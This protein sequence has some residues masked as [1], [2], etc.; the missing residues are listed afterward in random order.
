V[1]VDGLLGLYPINFDIDLAARLTILDVLGIGQL[2]SP[3]SSRIVS[4]NAAP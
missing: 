4:S 1:G 3:S 2:R